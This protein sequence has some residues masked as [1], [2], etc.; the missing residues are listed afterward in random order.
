MS[1]ALGQIPAAHPQK[2]L[3][4]PLA[5]AVGGAGSCLPL[6]ASHLPPRLHLHHT[7]CILL[8]E[9]MGAT[10]LE[11][12]WEILFVGLGSFSTFGHMA[13]ISPGKT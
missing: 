5:G 6:L 13:V 8:K 9:G 4:T 2:K 12:S 1:W 3:F 10:L 11:D 7:R